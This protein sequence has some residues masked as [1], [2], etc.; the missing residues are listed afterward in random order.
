[1]E[2]GGLIIIAAFVVILTAM[3]QL[4]A[5][6]EAITQSRESDRFS[7]R[8]RLLKTTADAA[9]DCDQA[10]GPLLGQK[11]TVVQSG[12]VMDSVENQRPNIRVDRVNNQHVRDVARLRAKRAARIANETAA[13]RRRM[14]TSG[15]LAIVTLLV[16]IVAVT[17]PLSWAWSLVPAGILAGSLVASRYAAIRSEK[18]NRE[19]IETLLELRDKLSRGSGARSSSSPETLTPR[20][21]EGTSERAEDEVHSPETLRDEDVDTF[22]ASDVSA[23]E[24]GEAELTLSAEDVSSTANV[25]RVE[26][27]DEQGPAPE[28]T[29]ERRGW[30]VSNIPAPMYAM[31]GRISARTVHSDTDLRGIPRVEASTPARPVEASTPAT[32]RSTEQVVAD[33]EVVLDLDAVL[34]S[35]RAQ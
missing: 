24:E 35:R 11:R 15:A 9:H 23:N 20:V 14:V 25:S 31:R 33:Q 16:F 6:R 3:P 18:T 17:T 13:A 27:T 30:T 19:E 4:V 2:Y 26:D 29:V 28:A 22:E 7:S 32:V 12:D 34:E 8:L 21:V 10:G 5:R 1:M